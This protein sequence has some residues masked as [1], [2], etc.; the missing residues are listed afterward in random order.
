MSFQS[1]TILKFNDLPMS[2]AVVTLLSY[3]MQNEKMGAFS[4]RRKEVVS[5]EGLFSQKGVAKSVAEHFKDVKSLL[6]NSVDFVDLKLNDVSYGKARFISFNF[7]TS[8]GFDENAISFSKFTIQLE[9]IRLDDDNA[10]ANSNLPSDAQGLNTGNGLWS[11]YKLKDFSENF[12]FKLGEDG[13]FEAS[14]SVS[15]QYDP[16]ETLSDAAL[17]AAAVAVANGFFKQ[18]LKDLSSIDSFYSSTDFQSSVSDYG[19]SLTEQSV[20]LINYKFAYSKNYT[21]FSQNGTNTSETITTE[22]SYKD[23]GSIEVSEKGR[24]KGKGT[25]YALARTNAIVKL[26]ANLLDAYTR[27]NGSFGRLRNII[28]KYNSS[29]VLQSNPISITK[30]LTDITP[31]VGYEIKFTTNPIFVDSALTHSYSVNIKKD[32]LGVC[33]ASINGSFKSLLNKK[34]SYSLSPT[35]TALANFDDINAINPY[36]KIIFNETANFTG[37][38]TASSIQSSTFGVE[39][40]YTKSYSNSPTLK[41]S[42]FT[43][44]QL[45]SSEALTI[46]INKYSTTSPIASKGTPAIS[47]YNKEIIYQ[48]RQLSEGS[49]SINLEMKIDRELLYGGSVNGCNQIASVIFGKIKYLFSE[50]MLHGQ[51]GYLFGEPDR[52]GV[53]VFA[54]IYKELNCKPGDL[55]FFLDSLNLS[56][57]DNYS[58]KATLVY[59]FL[60]A[61]EQ[62]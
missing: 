49:K 60:I 53:K 6:A 59:K 42:Q 57:D 30:D 12:S 3:S 17:S 36:Y 43:V 23:D 24:I 51:T 45:T 18:A 26:N 31:E 10:F 14:H 25:S 20:D 4:S 47:K 1:E 38:K 15:F 11:W 33:E 62:A 9:I 48:T 7:P 58:L 5:L 13:N 41:S 52:T 50:L 19:S 21:V 34:T 61:K 44:R 28:P 40:S 56:I 46:P 35:R 8:V 2:F 32:S 16:G 37:I 22:V 29:D 55:T 54:K 27:C 39:T